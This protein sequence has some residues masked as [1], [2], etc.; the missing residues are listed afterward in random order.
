MKRIATMLAMALI[1]G[2][3]LSGCGTAETATDSGRL[4]RRPI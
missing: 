3:A 1:V 4:T 2:I